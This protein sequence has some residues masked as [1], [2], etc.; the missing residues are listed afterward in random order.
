MR[1]ADGVPV[2]HQ[3]AAMS[4]RPRARG[5]PP[6]KPDAARSDDA[7]LTF[8]QL[9]YTQQEA[10]LLDVDPD[11]LKPIAFLNEA[12]HQQLLK[13]NALSDT[14]AARIEAHKQ[15]AAEAGMTEA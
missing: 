10:A 8:D 2:A 3:R 11:A 14:L 4:L 1:P 9:T 7:P 6:Q 13:A 12:H 5:S 15:V